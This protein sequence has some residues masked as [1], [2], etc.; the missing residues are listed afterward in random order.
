[1][2]ATELGTTH[3]ERAMKNRSSG[4]SDDMDTIAA[5]ARPH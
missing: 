4:S 1:M 3:R 5:L 2:A